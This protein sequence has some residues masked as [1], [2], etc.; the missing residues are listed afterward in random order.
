MPRRTLQ[1]LPEPFSLPDKI[2]GSDDVIHQALRSIERQINSIARYL[3]STVTSKDVL[4]PNGPINVSV[5]AVGGTAIITFQA[6]QSGPFI[7]AYRVYRADAGTRGTPTSPG[8]DSASCVGTLQAL[9]PEDGGSYSFQDRS[10]SVAQ[11]DPSDP[12]RF[13][14]WVTSMDDRDNES[15]F[16]QATNAPIETLPNGLGDL[17]PVVNYSPFQK[18]PFMFQAAAVAGP[19]NLVAPVAISSSTNVTPPVITTSSAHGL[20]VGDAVWIDGHDIVGDNGYW[21]VASTPLGT[22][23]TCTG[24]VAG[25]VGTAKGFVTKNINKQTVP[26]AALTVLTDPDPGSTP[27]PQ[28]LCYVPWYTDSTSTPAP[29]LTSG[30]YPGYGDLKLLSPAS[31]ITNKAY[32]ELPA[33]RI[34]NRSSERVT[35]SV[36]VSLN[37]VDPTNNFVIGVDKET[38]ANGGVYSNVASFSVPAATIGSASAISGIAFWRVV[39]TFSQVATQPFRY[40][41]WVGN[42]A[43][44]AGGTANFDVWSP[45]VNVGDVAA[46]PTSLVDYNDDGMQVQNVSPFSRSNQYSVFRSVTYGPFA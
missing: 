46:H 9:R 4:V 35:F 37:T 21:V 2:E 31:A 7:E 18:S 41:F 17:S 38:G 14:Y 39:M 11:M 8:P 45:L 16:V 22:T 1:P 19:T 33:R 40:R 26:T 36:L 30:L 15:I 5:S 6:D 13:N 44:G 43:T 12:S 10:F 29:Q 24:M 42:Q 23:F 34:A 32:F 3:G 20:T 25:G 28:L 27:A